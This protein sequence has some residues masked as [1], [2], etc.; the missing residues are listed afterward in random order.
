MDVQSD[1]IQQHL[2]ELYLQVHY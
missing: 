2:L 1:V